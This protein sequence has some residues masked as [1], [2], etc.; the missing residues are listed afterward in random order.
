MPVWT[1]NFPSLED[2]QV[3]V[4][5]PGAGAGH[6]SGAPSAVLDDG[7]W[8]L[9]YRVR[10]PLHAGRGMA[11]VVAQSTD[12][13]SFTTVCHVLRDEFGAESFERPALV[14]K[15]GGGWR[16]FL[17]CATPGSKHWWIEALDADE[18]EGLPDGE[19]SV[20][21]PGSDEVA[22]K[23]PVVVVDDDG[24]W[25]MWACEHPL[26][27]VGHEDR[28]RTAHFTSSDG[29]AWHR[30][31]TALEGR[32]GMW[33]ARGSRVTAILERDPLVALYD[34]RAKAEQNWFET[35][36][37]AH[38]QPDA[39]TSDSNAPVLRSPHS[40]GALRYVS[41]VPLPDGAVRYFFEMA[42]P[43]GAHDL[44]TSLSLP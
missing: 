29:L 43:D 20:I 32:S 27:E 33:D 19:R 4:P 3:V 26:T 9:A 25:Q 5:A 8:L 35:T 36:G 13:V 6:W 16:L 44:M 34:G 39:L 21:L 7:T 30:T 24:G 42:R 41:A 17:S 14:H 28:M 1:F 12:G 2:A 38:G 31:G 22:I 18:V 40:D 23:D 11:I 10:R 37:V 15:P